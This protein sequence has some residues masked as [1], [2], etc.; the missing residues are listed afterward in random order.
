MQINP[1]KLKKYAKKSI[2]SAF[3]IIFLKFTIHAYLQEVEN[4]WMPKFL[5]TTLVVENPEE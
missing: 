1:P 5:R 3:L 2:K 4:P